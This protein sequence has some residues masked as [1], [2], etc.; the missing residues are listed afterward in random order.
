MLAARRPWAVSSTVDGGGGIVHVETDWSRGLG[1]YEA[2]GA[3][4][5][6]RVTSWP[7]RWT[8]FGF[9][10][11]RVRLLWGWSAGRLRSRVYDY[12]E[13]VRW[14]SA[15]FTSSNFASSV[16]QPC[17]LSRP[18]LS[19]S[20]VLRFLAVERPAFGCG[21][22]PAPVRPGRRRSAGLPGVAAPG[23]SISVCCGGRG[24]VFQQGQGC[25]HA[26]CRR[27]CSLWSSAGLGCCGGWRSAAG[28]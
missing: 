25:R 23:R 20:R 15:A 26:G 27:R 7:A 18:R 1:G 17:A 4:I 6:S 28:G 14:V 21:S 22:A 10:I 8:K 11:A 3:L 16:G 19:C 2:R 9:I 12:D 24:G 5:P 13:C